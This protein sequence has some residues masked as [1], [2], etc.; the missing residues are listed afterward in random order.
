MQ[1]IRLV[2]LIDTAGEPFAV[3][4]SRIPPSRK[5][6]RS[7]LLMGH[8]DAPADAAMAAAIGNY[9]DMAKVKQFWA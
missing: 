5:R 7:N 4:S 8:E 1:S 3:V 6:V 2:L 9:A